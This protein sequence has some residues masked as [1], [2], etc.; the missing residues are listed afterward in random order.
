MVDV[1]KNM[2]DSDFFSNKLTHIYF[3]DYVCN[4]SINKLIN[5]IN[6]ANKETKT[7]S[8]AILKPKPILIH[9]SSH[10]GNLTDGMRLFSVF[11]MS[12]TPIAT[13]VDNYSCSAATYL[14][15]NSPYR[16]INKYG[17]CLIHGYIISGIAKKK[18]TQLQDMVKLYDTYFSKIVD[19]YKE[20]TKFQHD[21][22]IELLQHDLLLDSKFCLEKGIVDRII[23]INPQTKNTQ[24]KNNLKEIISNP[25][26]SIRIS[27]TNM[28]EE[29]D[30][31]LFEDNL[32]PV[33]IYPRQNS[34][35]DKDEDKD[36]GNVKET[37]FETL[38][39]IPRILN[40]KQ[41][42]YAI[43]DSPISIDDLLPMLYCDYIFIFDYAYIVSN[44]LYFH[45]KSGILI[46]D[47]I[48]N[49]ELIFDTIAQ[50]LKEKTKMD[51][52]MI[53]NIKNKFNIINPVQAKKLG[54][55]NNIIR[56]NNYS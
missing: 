25:Y 34:C 39:I 42:T 5:S 47:N 37:I 48:K 29:L 7:E 16:L 1:F 28:I 26:N 40:L 2:S 21:E 44:I 20:R 55:C 24:I 13:I 8:G 15:I 14:S 19:I 31:I 30:K 35:L 46:N 38:N 17:Y 45:S 3:N 56:R 33:I 9:I 52:E 51:D 36:D 18:Q 43:I 23:T 12:K 50:I 41:P 6:E 27:C 10:G 32:S 54:L 53:N 22:L 11:A 49:T 4:K